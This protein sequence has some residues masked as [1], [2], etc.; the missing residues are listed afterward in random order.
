MTVVMVEV[1]SNPQQLKAGQSPWPRPGNLKGGKSLKR[2]VSRVPQG[3]RRM[4][5]ECLSLQERAAEH[6]H[7]CRAV[8][9]DLAT[10][11][12]TTGVKFDNPGR[13]YTP[14]RIRRGVSMLF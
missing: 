3:Y 9:T 5:I 2:R 14:S 7:K 11:A 10:Q 1:P 12:L 8:F 4:G 6:R 13:I